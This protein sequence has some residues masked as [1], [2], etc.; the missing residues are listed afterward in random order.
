VVGTTTPA[1]HWS[2]VKYYFNLDDGREYFSDD[3]GQEFASDDVAHAHALRIVAD[4][5]ADEL[6]QRTSEIRVMVS[7]T[8]SMGSEC[9]RVHV[10]ASVSGARTGC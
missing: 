5:V 7:I 3:F 1:T 6:K 4:I 8:D 10:A 9:I 2:V